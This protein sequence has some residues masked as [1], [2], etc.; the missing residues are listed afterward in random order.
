MND[1]NIKVGIFAY[2]SDENRSSGCHCDDVRNMAAMENLIGDYIVNR[3]VN[4][5]IKL[6]KQTDTEYDEYYFEE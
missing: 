1:N 3:M 5:G 6:Q 2:I 4:D